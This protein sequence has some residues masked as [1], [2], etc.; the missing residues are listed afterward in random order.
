MIEV[1]G[2]TKDFVD[3][4]GFK[5]VLLK[6]VSFRLIPGI[7]TSIVAPNGA[8]KSTLAKIIS[9][10]D[11]AYTGEIVSLSDNKIIFMPGKPSS[12][13]WLDV[14]N[15]IKL[16]LT[17][18]DDTEILNLI[19][20]V[21]LEGYEHY[22]P[23]N[24]SFGFRFRV[25]L[26]RAL[27]NSSHTI[28]IDEPFLLMDVQTKMEILLLIRKINRLKKVSFLL[29]TT[30]ITEA[31]FLSDIIYLMKKNPGEIISE[32]KINL[33]KIRSKKTFELKNYIHY[34]NLIEKTLKKIESH[35]LFNI[36]I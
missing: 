2:L 9:G 13:P 28:I 36:S 30:N 10:L 1:N 26:A 8:G 35:Q 5:T 25:A 17:N 23:N 12:F 4:F 34:R 16:G 29:T 7:I 27:A 14:Y 19:G 15:N 24:N 33:P 11:T 22:F 6:N 18:C 21:G 20:L 3:E 31:V 32:I